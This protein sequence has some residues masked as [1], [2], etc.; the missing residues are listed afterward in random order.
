MNDIVL[1]MSSFIWKVTLHAHRV[2]HKF[3]EITA[4][5]GITWSHRFA[6]Y[7]AVDTASS[8]QGAQ[9]TPE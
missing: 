4:E 1:T 2:N 7:S 5:V 8:T 3:V 9:A 6:G